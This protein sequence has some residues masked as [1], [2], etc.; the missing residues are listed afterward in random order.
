MLPNIELMNCQGLTVPAKIMH[1]VIRVES[2][3]N[4]Y[5]IG[6]VGG[7]LARQPRNLPE[8]LATVRMLES[9]GFNFS[10]G[11]AQVNRYNLETYGL[12][13]YER[14]FQACPNV[15]AGSRILAE[16]Y[17]RSGKNW[18]RSLSCYYSG[19]FVTGYRDGYV[20]KIFASMHKA[21]GAGSAAPPIAVVVKPNRHGAS[22]LRN[23]LDES[24]AVMLRHAASQGVAAPV[25][26][27][28]SGL[29]E[30][31]PRK[32]DG[33]DGLAALVPSTPP[34]A[35]PLTSDKAADGSDRRSSTDTAFVF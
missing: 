21:S 27:Q 1:H 35:T 11:L 23:S 8:A 16:C 33:H 2:S 26:A 19:D 14:A 32:G 29:H 34:P 28:T 5:A 18:G 22:V 20:Q 13:S 9:R 25:H 31:R 15:L 10:L 12:G 24:Q 4:P 30:V 3:F 6:V 7:H 17:N